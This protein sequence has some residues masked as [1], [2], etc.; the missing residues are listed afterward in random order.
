MYLHVIGCMW[1]FLLHTDEIWEPRTM[2][3]SGESI[4]D[5]SYFTQYCEGFYYASILFTGNDVSP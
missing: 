1:F 3:L 2:N 4:Y 5:K